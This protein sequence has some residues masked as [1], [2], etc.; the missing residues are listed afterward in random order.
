[1]VSHS[2]RPSY[3]TD[4]RSRQQTKVKRR[5]IYPDIKEGTKKHV[6]GFLSEVERK[7]LG[8][9]DKR[10]YNSLDGRDILICRFP[11]DVCIG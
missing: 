7:D 2:L 8:S 11:V 10:L 4:P 1:M 3:D 5:F 9:S 6:R